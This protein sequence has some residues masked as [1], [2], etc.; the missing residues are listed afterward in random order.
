MDP[1]DLT[2]APPRS[3][4]A[5][6][7]GLCMLPRMIDIAR[8]QQPGGRAGS[9][10]I[11]RGFSGMVFYKLG[12][13]A[14]E[15]RE[16]VAAAADDEAVAEKVVKGLDEAAIARLNARLEGA[17][18]ADIPP[19][20]RPIFESFYGPNVPAERNMFDFLEDDDAGK[21]VGGGAAAKPA[22]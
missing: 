18:V 20:L 7:R 15:F 17:C 2:H 19:D 3:P 16:I 9:Y 13:G 6:L 22:S 11:G 12:L 14:P 4:R 21:I 1:L 5:T 10:Q 8:A